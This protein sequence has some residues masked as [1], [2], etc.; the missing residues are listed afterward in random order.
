LAA[1]HAL[2]LILVHGIGPQNVSNQDV[3]LQHVRTATE[4]Y[5]AR[6]GKQGRSDQLCT[7]RADWSHLF[8]NQQQTWLHTLFP[9]HA[10]PSVRRWRFLKILGYVAV[11][12][13]IVAVGAGYGVH[14][15]P[16]IPGWVLGTLAGLLVAALIEWFVILPRFPWGHIWTMG[17][18][19]EAGTVS[20]VI[21]Y[22]SDDPRQKILDVV[23]A[24]LAPY[25][26][27]AYAFI[28]GDAKPYLPV[29]LVGHSLGTIVVYDLLLGISARAKHAKTAVE[30]ELETAR[31]KVEIGV[32]PDKNAARLA[33][34][35]RMQSI[36]EVVYPVGMIT[37]GSPI[38]LFLFRKPDLA[39][40]DNLWKD[41]CPPAFSANGVV[42]THTGRDLC[43]RWQNFWHASDFVAH[44]LSPLFNAG[45]PGRD[46]KFV[47]DERTYSRARDPV[48]AH[49]TYW[50]EWKVLDRIGEHVAG[51]LNALV[52]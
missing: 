38:A 14:G 23:Y 3:F 29:V 26:S 27:E 17:R 39:T 49:A 12:P 40:R 42:K 48:S 18:P 44:R 46:Y 52:R 33:F 50:T 31:H 16:P 47:D 21:L 45:Y 8:T 9:D 34:L 5:L 51:V 4:K 10:M 7:L 25:F 20:D 30:R 2:F 11:I 41:A 13:L 24:Q 32:D 28:D 36:Q 15:L 43:W 1:A 6:F 22:Q 37:L 35:K 19:F